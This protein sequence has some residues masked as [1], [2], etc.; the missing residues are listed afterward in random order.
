LITSSAVH[1]S[2][3]MSGLGGKSQRFT[4]SRA[5]HISVPLGISP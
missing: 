1:M 2:R 4:Q 3:P 5:Y